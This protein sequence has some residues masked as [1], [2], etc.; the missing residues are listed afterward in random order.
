MLTRGE[1]QWPRAVTLIL[2]SDRLT[3]K[4]VPQLFFE[5]TRVGT[6][7]RMLVKHPTKTELVKWAGATGDYYPYHYDK[8]AAQQAGLPDV[9]V[10]G[11]LIA[12]FLGQM[13]TDWIGPRGRVRELSVSN[14]Q[15]CLPGQDVICQGKVTKKWV[16][17]GE[18]L[19]MCQISAKNRRRET[20]VLGTATVILPSSKT[21]SL[22]LEE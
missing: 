9:I 20:M 15:M 19:V 18:C 12:S 22:A 7:V 3:G 6:K 10:Q 14:K 17:G 2:N 8:D 16:K 1:K 21:M 5:N 11:L 4:M 13:L